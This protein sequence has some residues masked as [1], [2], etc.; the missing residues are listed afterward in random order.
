M[1]KIQLLVIIPILFLCS[2]AFAQVPDPGTD[3]TGWAGTLFNL[4]TSKQWG[5]VVGL[6]LVGAVYLL[7]KLPWL[8]KLG[9]WGQ[10][11][12]NVGVTVATTLAAALYVHTAI[13][14]ALVG[15]AVTNALI[16]AGT[17]ELIRDS[18]E[19]K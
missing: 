7:K 8:S 6:V 1:R 18:I 5:P 3:L 17:L 19:N 14:F 16:A 2:W 13:T 9:R 4:I 12:L 10:W 15:V 11:A